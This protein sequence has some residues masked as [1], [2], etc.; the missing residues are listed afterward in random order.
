MAF[1]SYADISAA[2]GEWAARG[3][4]KVLGQVSNFVRLGEERIWKR[5][6]VSWGVSLPITLTVPAGQNWVA[7]PDDWLAFKR[8]Q[9][10]AE[11]LLEYMPVDMLLDLPEPGNPQRYSIEG[12]RF[13]YG[14][15][16]AADLAFTAR[17]Y[18]HPGFLEVAGSTWL[19]TKAPSVYLYAALL[20]LHIFTKNAARVAEF[21]SLLDRAIDELD[22]ADR[23]AMISGSRLRVS[24][25]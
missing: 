10:A 18:Q 2:V 6:R 15:T 20:E 7:L 12:G 21:G 3:D 4:A 14:Q 22:S 5:L 13:Y 8:I 19:L 17:Y 1:T 24:R 16:P 11:P 25:G 23:A 9:T